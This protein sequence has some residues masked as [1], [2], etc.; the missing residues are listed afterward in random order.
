[1]AH[2]A[3]KQSKAHKVARAATLTT[4]EKAHARRA[5]IR[6]SEN[7]KARIEEAR[8]PN[9]VGQE[10]A[11]LLSGLIFIGGPEAGKTV[12][13]KAAQFGPKGF[14][15]VRK[16]LAGKIAQIKSGLNT[17]RPAVVSRVLKK[18]VGKP[19]R[20]FEIASKARIKERVVPIIKGEK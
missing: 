8:G 6:R 17:T 7:E 4:G 3:S 12:A 10:S 13:R 14:L 1:M 15:A 18:M 9:P 5:K 19:S 11:D 16:T 20:G 2:K